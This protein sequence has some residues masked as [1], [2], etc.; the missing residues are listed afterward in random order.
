MNSSPMLP[1]TVLPMYFKHSK[2]VIDRPLRHNAMN[3]QPLQLLQF[4]STI[5][6]LWYVQSAVVVLAY[7]AKSSIDRVIVFIFVFT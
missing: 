6:F 5:E 1:Q 2:Y 3:S 7:I 4:C